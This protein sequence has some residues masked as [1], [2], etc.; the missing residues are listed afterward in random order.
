MHFI[1]II[2]WCFLFLIAFA[3]L[4]VLDRL[5]MIDLFSGIDRRITAKERQVR[6][7]NARR[8]A[9]EQATA[10]KNQH[11]AERRA[12]EKKESARMSRLNDM[13]SLR[14]LERADDQHGV[15]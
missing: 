15:D 12:A 13:A 8:A 5:G 2:D 14:A 10:E 4:N 6:R 1:K 9:A 7:Q 3:L 11:E